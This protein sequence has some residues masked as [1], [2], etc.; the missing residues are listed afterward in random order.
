MQ[1]EL[2]KTRKALKDKEKE[3]AKVKQDITAVK[4]EQADK[5]KTTQPVKDQDT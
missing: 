1:K 5:A 4:K 2:Q 3:L